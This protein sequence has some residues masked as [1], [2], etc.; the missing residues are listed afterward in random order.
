MTLTAAHLGASATASAYQDESRPLAAVGEATTWL[1]SSPQTAATLAG[2]VVLVQFGTYTCINWLRTL[3]YVRAWAQKYT[4]QLTVIMVHTPEFAFERDLAKV[5]RAVRQ[6]AVGFPLAVDND[7]AI[8]R[9]FNNQ[10]WPALYFFDRRGRLRDQ[11]FGEGRYERSEQVI[12]E[13]LAETG[14][15]TDDTT[16]VPTGATGFEV[17]ADWRNRRSPELYLGHRRA[18]NFSS[19]GGVTRAKRRLYA[20]PAGLAA[21]HWALAGE[22]TIRDEPAVSNLASGHIVCR[23]HA[24]DVHL[25]MGPPRQDRPV[26]F[27]ITVDGRPPGAAHGADVD[28]AGAGTVS[29][30]RL[31][32]LLRQP[33]PIVERTLDIEFVDRGVEAFAF[34]FG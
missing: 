4:G 31:Y 28:D 6:L 9:G 11:H 23:F 25:V 10:F 27:R 18:V 21:N 2:R 29:D 16:V 26:P 1:N 34:T 17:Q 7:Y 20:A 19:P 13:L 15:R 5:R 3:P 30:H 32:G 33:G 24:R 14:V 12:R 22:W 8:W